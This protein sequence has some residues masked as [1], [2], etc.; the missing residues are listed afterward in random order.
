MFLFDPENPF[1]LVPEACLT[2][3]EAQLHS[4][5]VDEWLGL[6]AQAIENQ[7]LSNTSYEQESK[8]VQIWQGL[9]LQAMQ[10]PY[11]EIRFLLS[12]LALQD[13][14]T[15][16]DLGCSY[17]RLAHVLGRHYPR[18]RFIGYELVDER[19]REGQRV[20]RKFNYPH[21]YLETKNLSAED[22]DLPSANFYFI[23]DFGSRSAIDKTLHDLRE[24]AQKRKIT[25][26]ARGRGI[27]HQIY[28]NHPWLAQM[29]EPQIHNHFTIFYS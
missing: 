5:H 1:P 14:D 26:I 17:G 4:A 8:D 18:V 6:K 22:F 12:L 27:R 9:P 25:V 11:I 3:H 13:G 28:Q 19:V 20:L 16:L 21:V 24:M 23:F 29:N 15:V 10:T 2:Y 7:L